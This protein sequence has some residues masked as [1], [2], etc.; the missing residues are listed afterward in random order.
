MLRKKININLL[1][2]KRTNAEHKVIEKKMAMIMD[3]LN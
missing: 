1:K 3:A 2:N